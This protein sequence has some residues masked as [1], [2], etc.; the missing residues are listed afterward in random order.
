MLCQ[1]ME[2]RPERETDSGRHLSRAND[3]ILPTDDEFRVTNVITHSLG[4]YD[5][6]EGSLRPVRRAA[7]EAGTP[8][9]S[10]M[11]SR[12]RR[13]PPRKTT[14][15]KK[16]RKLI[17]S[18]RRPWRRPTSNAYVEKKRTAETC[19]KGVGA[20]MK[21]S[22]KPRWATRTSSPPPN[23]TSSWPRHSVTRSSPC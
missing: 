1:I 20:S 11:R 21:R 15:N 4:H 9:E 8:S 2:L 19:S 12:K 22:C 6:G 3:V 18:S 23:K 10:F 14:N 7:A 17:G 5:H 16:T 13:P